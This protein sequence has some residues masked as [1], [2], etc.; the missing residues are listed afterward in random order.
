MVLD[1][2]ASV[3]G[4][5]GQFALKALGQNVTPKKSRIR[6]RKNLTT[7]VDRQTNIFFGSLRDLSEKKWRL[8]DFSQNKKNP[9]RSSLPVARGGGEKITSRNDV[10]FLIYIFISRVLMPL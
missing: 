8:H 2:L 6:E 3:P 5:L 10:H 9:P 1:G 4:A 7:D